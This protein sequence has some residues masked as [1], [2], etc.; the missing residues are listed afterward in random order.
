MPP[1][2]P[3]ERYLRTRF[4]RRNRDLLRLSDS[5]LES[6]LHQRRGSRG[7][8]PAG[9]G[10]VTL[11]SLVGAGRLPAENELISQLHEAGYTTVKTKNLLPGDRF[12]AFQAFRA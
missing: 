9:L 7:P 2:G 8:A 5:G 4:P 10:P 1:V 3:D 6:D 12:M 11:D